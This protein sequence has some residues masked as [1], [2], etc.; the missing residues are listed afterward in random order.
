MNSD[1]LL[2]AVNFEGG[3]YKCSQHLAFKSF[4]YHY[5]GVLA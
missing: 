1:R 3:M 5:V 4:I 2:A